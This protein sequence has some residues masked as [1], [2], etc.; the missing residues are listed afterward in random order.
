M[1]T[2]EST[3][4]Y[5]D[6]NFKCLSSCHPESTTDNIFMNFLPVSYA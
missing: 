2:F 1:Y 4:K 3:Q 5:K 6:K